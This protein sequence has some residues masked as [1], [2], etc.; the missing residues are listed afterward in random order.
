MN[1]RLIRRRFHPSLLLTFLLCLFI[2]VSWSI[3]NTSPTKEPN[4]PSLGDMSSGIVSPM[5][6]YWLG[7]A[8]LRQFRRQVA[9]LNDPIV[10][11]YLETLVYRL[12]PSSGLGNW[13]LE[14]V[15]VDNDDLNAFAVPGGVLGLNTGTFRYA[16]T[17]AEL[18]SILAHELAHLSQRHFARGI[19]ESR[20]NQVPAL[21]AM[22]AS[23]LL[24]ATVGGD[25]GFAALATTQAMM[26]DQY[27]RFSRKNEAEAD[28]LGLVTLQ[29]ANYDP[30]SMPMMF[31]RMLR[32]KRFSGQNPPEFMLTHPLTESRIADTRNR[33]E[34]YPKRASYIR[35]TLQYHIIK[36]RLKVLTV[37]NPGELVKYYRA[38]V[39]EGISPYPE[40]DLYGLMLAYDKAEKHEQ[41]KQVLAELLRINPEKIEYLL[42]Q[43]EL[44]IMI[45]QPE[46]AI[47]LLQE[48]LELRPGYYPLEMKLVRAYR[49]N[50]NPNTAVKILER[51]VKKRPKDP[52]IWYELAE[53]R[54][55][56][57]DQLGVHRAR[58]EYFQL[59]GAFSDAK[60]Q[61]EFA[62]QRADQKFAV[63]AV[64]EQRIV[65]INQIQNASRRA[66]ESL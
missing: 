65:E 50:K 24:M 4:L 56:T 49:F 39:D 27:L 15:I 9:T 43:S 20:D 12:V 36:A 16:R 21:A 37:Q 25:A 38:K 58:A 7:R 57:G 47:T 28:R 3:A 46:K 18:A 23:I 51:I 62:L 32:T 40:T 10:V 8:W 13:P 31:E 60:V 41:A 26:Q 55:L 48:Q 53:M 22:L 17:E 30:M 29:K 52:Y 63:T 6:E 64:I 11:Q 5:Q 1:S 61:L 42:A 35:D 66:M 2:P 45:D 33:A 54:G 14:L 19:E 44:E 59:L 34:Q